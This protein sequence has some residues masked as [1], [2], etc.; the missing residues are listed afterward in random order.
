MSIMYRF[1]LYILFFATFAINTDFNVASAQ[2]R[3]KLVIGT[4]F[5]SSPY[6]FQNTSKKGFDAELFSTLFTRMGYDIEI[7]HGPI[8]RLPNLLKNNEIDIMATWLDTSLPCSKSKPYRYWQNAILTTSDHRIT[9]DTPSSLSGK[10]V[11]SF[12]GASKA[13]TKELD[14]DIDSFA[15]YF[16]VPSSEHAAKMLLSYRFD[17]YI[18]DA[19]AV[20]H[21]Y[22]IEVK[23]QN[24]QSTL[25]VNYL[26]SPTPQFLCF[27]NDKLKNHFEK[28]LA[29]FHATGEYDAL[30]IKYIPNVATLK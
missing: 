18:G 16:E 6:I 21:F 8:N 17:A 11:G 19:W 30:K 14:G 28:E 15:D 24:K 5:E 9:I 10:V 1:Q 20:S 23:K 12:L 26:F 2:D 22:D 3:Q 29:N 25:I 13:M 7:L 4:T 27:N